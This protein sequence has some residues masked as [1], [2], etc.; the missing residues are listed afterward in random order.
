MIGYP[1]TIAKVYQYEGIDP[2]TGLYKFTDFNGDGKIT[3]LMI[4]K[5]WK[6]WVSAFWRMVE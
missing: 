1:T 4:I 2:A 6:S 5:Q 3:S